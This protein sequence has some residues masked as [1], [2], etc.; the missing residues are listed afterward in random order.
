MKQQMEH[1]VEHHVFLDC[2]CHHYSALNVGEILAQEGTKQVPN[3]QIS[4]QDL[5]ARDHD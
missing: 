1:S 5:K 2:Q 3:T 4:Y